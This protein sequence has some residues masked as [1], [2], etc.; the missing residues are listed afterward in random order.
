MI[1]QIV[2]FL[3]SYNRWL[4]MAV[5]FYA[6][7]RAWHGLLSKRA[8]TNTDNITALAFTWLVTLQFVLGLI[9][10]LF[11]NGLAQTAL[12]VMSQDFGAAMKTRDLRFFGMEHPLQM[13]IALI[14]AHLGGARSRKTHPSANQFRWAVICFT[15]AALLIFSGIPWWRPLLRAF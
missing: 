7:F 2:L 9:L 6:L 12:Q 3:H 11:P 8:W 14:I 15:L 1:Y 5:M 10:Y 13:V 4:V